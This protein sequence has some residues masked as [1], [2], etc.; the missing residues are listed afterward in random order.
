MLPAL[1]K[2]W[3]FG[4]NLAVPSG[5]NI[6][7]TNH[8]L[9]W[10]TYNALCGRKPDNSGPID[11]V[12]SDGNPASAPAAVWVPQSESNSLAVGNN[13][14][15]KRINTFADVVYGAFGGPG[16]W[17]H[18]YNSALGLHIKAYFGSAATSG[19]DSAGHASTEGEQSAWNM[20]FVGFGAA[21]GGTN[22]TTSTPPLTDAPANQAK[23]S[24]SDGGTIEN[25]T[26]DSWG[27]TAIS[28]T[29]HRLHVCVSDDGKVWRIFA[30]RNGRSCMFINIEAPRDPVVIKGTPDRTWNG[31]DKP[32]VAWALGTQQDDFNNRVLRQTANF[33][34]NQRIAM[35]FL[36]Q[37]GNANLVKRAMMTF[38]VENVCGTGFNL[39]TYAEQNVG[40]SALT[41]EYGIAPLALWSREP[42]Q[43]GRAGLCND[44]YHGQGPEL[45]GPQEGDSY[46]LLPAPTF[47]FAHFGAFVHPWCKLPILTS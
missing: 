17:S 4:P 44:L 7:E 32:I 33:N 28:T 35:T 8:Y 18:L 6:V 45:G 3:R 5:I 27:G 12:D 14:L 39:Q 26:I 34:A 46:P 42:G 15:V 37:A 36:A 19:T 1:T 30:F 38:G 47:E 43:M 2:T 21:V 24:K 22:G 41:N 40:P 29:A 16:T 25:S 20:S 13:D 31:L 9:W 11:W 23:F 10:A